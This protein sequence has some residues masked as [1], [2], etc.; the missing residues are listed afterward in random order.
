MMKLIEFIYWEISKIL[1][2]VSK[3][4]L[5]SIPGEYTSAKLYSKNVKTRHNEIKSELLKKIKV[6]DAR[7]ISNRRNFINYLY[8]SCPLSLV[9][10]IDAPNVVSRRPLL[11]FWWYL[12]SRTS[13]VSKLF[14]RHLKLCSL[15]PMGQISIIKNRDTSPGHLIYPGKPWATWTYYRLNYLHEPCHDIH[16]LWEAALLRTNHLTSAKFVWTHK[17]DIHNSR[18]WSTM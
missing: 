4:E 8:I 11:W 18:M 2:I 9:H 17:D 12:L 1:W 13:V 10:F 7:K 3:S 6:I 15:S 16:Y 14:H 5:Y